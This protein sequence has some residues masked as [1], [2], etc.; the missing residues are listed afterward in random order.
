MSTLF[1]KRC[2][3]REMFPFV[4]SHNLSPYSDSS[5]EGDH[6][7]KFL[8]QSCALLVKG[9]KDNT[10][11]SKYLSWQ[12]NADLQIRRYMLK[13]IL[14]IVVQMCNGRTE[15]TLFYKKL[16]YL[17]KSFESQLYCSAESRDEYKDN[18]TIEAS[19]LVLLRNKQ[20]NSKRMHLFK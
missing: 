4:K 6:Q 9:T 12:S 8:S 5:V 19:V 14:S 16:P 1:K 15:E 20:A 7:K 13:R 2:L 11:G 17:A 10:E 18:N 3:Q